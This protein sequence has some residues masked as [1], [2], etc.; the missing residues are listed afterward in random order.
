[1]SGRLKGIVVLLV[2]L[3][4]LMA[5]GCSQAPEGTTDKAATPKTEKPA[6]E[7]AV[8]TGKYFSPEPG[9]LKE[10]KAEVSIEANIES[11]AGAKD[12]RVWIPYPRSEEYQTITD[13]KVDG[14]FV[15]QEIYEGEDGNKILYAEW[16]SPQDKPN[17]SF[18]FKVARKEINRKNFPSKE[19]TSIPSDIEE[20]YLSATGL[21][22]TDGEPKEIAAK[23][24]E[25]KESIFSKAEAVYD[26]IVENYKRDNA[27]KGCGKGDVCQLITTKQG[28]CADI[29]SVFVSLA[30]SAGV[31]ARETFGIRTKAEKEGDITGAYHCI[32]EFYMP[33]YGWVPV[34][35]SDVLKKMLMDNLALDDP[36][37]KE[38]RNYFFGAQNETY[39]SLSSGRDLTLN[40]PQKAGKLNYF[41]YPYCEVDGKALDHLS[42]EDFKYKVT[43]KEI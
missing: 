10:K 5:V 16:Q 8:D 9:E 17:L 12:V 27:I 3:L 29:H 23:I 6:E 42:Q 13:A 21:V 26:H 31:P 38:A 41:M 34:D 36:K 19:K 37:I 33:G 20:K 40:P 1:M 4:G 2:L 11:F 25:G 18:K 24:T 15:K 32:A 35:A 7:I 14:N 28:K 30:R 43:Y 39:I 22:V